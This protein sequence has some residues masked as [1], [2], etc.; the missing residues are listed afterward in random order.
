MEPTS[1]WVGLDRSYLPI[2]RFSIEQSDAV[3]AISNDLKKSTIESFEI[4]SLFMYPQFVNCDLYRRDKQP[5]RGAR[6][7]QTGERLA[8]ASIELPGR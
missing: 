8:C 6:S 3:T 2:T 1:R 5:R 7:C 4:T